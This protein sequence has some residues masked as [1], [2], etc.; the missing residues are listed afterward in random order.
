MTF[1]EHMSEK[2]YYFGFGM[3][4]WL[5]LVVIAVIS[6]LLGAVHFILPNIFVAVVVILLFVISEY[7]H[8]KR[9]SDKSSHKKEES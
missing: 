9:R 1:N 4:R 2:A 7:W 6:L 3:T 8:Y 5:S